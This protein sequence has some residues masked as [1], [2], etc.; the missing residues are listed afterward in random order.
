RAAH[1][2]AEELR[3]RAPDQ[4]EL[5]HRPSPLRHGACSGRAAEPPLDRGAGAGLPALRDGRAGTILTLR[6]SERPVR[7]ASHICT[8]ANLLERIGVNPGLGYNST[9]WRSVPP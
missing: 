6:L 1:Q 7:K 8:A 3:Q 5:R 4:P 2:V 9:S